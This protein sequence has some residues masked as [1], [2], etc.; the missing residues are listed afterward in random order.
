MVALENNNISYPHGAFPSVLTCSDTPLPFSETIS[1]FEQLKIYS[2]NIKSPIY[3]FL[4]YDLKNELEEIS[5]KNPDGMGFPPIGFIAPELSISFFD[6]YVKITAEAPNETYQNIIKNDYVSETFELKNKIASRLDREEYIKRVE[7]IQSHIQRGDIYE[8][9]FCNEYFSE[10]ADL[11]PTEVYFKLATLSPMPFAAFV[12]WNDKYLLCA[13]PERYLKKEGENL[14]SQPI[15][16]TIRRGQNQQEDEFLKQKL[17]HSEKER[18]E[19]IMIVD[20]VRNDFSHT[21][22]DGSVKVEELCKIYTFKQ[23]HQMISTI[24]ATQSKNFH[25]VDTL[26]HCFP[27]GSMTGAPKLSAMELIEHFE[28][29]KRGLFSG[30]VGYISPE[31]N[32]DFNVVI[33]SILYNSSTKYL[34]FQ[35]GSAITI[36]AIAEQEW[37]ECEV[38]IAAIKKAL[39]V[40]D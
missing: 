14:V 39:S 11:S 10:N 8:L 26:R 35:A 2:Q 37:E 24:V 33:R 40:N 3:G 21:A 20:L 7:R 30:S 34:S 6:Q 29:R 25:F 19:N 1:Y 28:T 16:G 13:S 17:S 4:T 18:A 12:K 32:F 36:D 22:K 23:V 5:S 15:K 31:G 9:N 38:K 27:M